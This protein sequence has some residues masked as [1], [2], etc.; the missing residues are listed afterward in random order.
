MDVS[1][2]IIGKDVVAFWGPVPG[3]NGERMRG[4]I[5]GYHDHPT[6]LIEDEDGNQITWAAK[7]CELEEPLGVAWWACCGR[8]LGS[9]H[10]DCSLS[11]TTVPFEY[12]LAAK[13][14]REGKFLG[15]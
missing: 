10:D 9:P 15:V 6:L 14:R 1:K 7:L 8:S 4:K 12:D 5:V 11:V 3:K 13:W 2:E